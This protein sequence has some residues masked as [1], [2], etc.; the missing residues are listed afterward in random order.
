MTRSTV[1]SSPL[2]AGGYSSDFKREYWDVVP[3]PHTVCQDLVQRH[4]YAKGGS[5]TA[6]YCHGLVRRDNPERVVGIAWWL[7]PT[8]VAAESVS[9][10]WTR[11]LSLTRTVI[12]PGVPKNAATF[13]LSKSVKLIKIDGRL[14]TLVT[15]ADERAGHTGGVYRAANWTYVGRTGPYVKWVAEDG[16]QVAAK[17]TKARTKAEMEALGPVRLGSFHKHKYVLRLPARKYAP[18]AGGG[19]SRVP[20]PPSAVPGRT[21]EG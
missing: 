17:A 15:Y 18:T 19:T 14:H 11:V 20:G 21:T 8:R 3:V 6:V 2:S 9:D 16:R 7:P 1:G 10:D 12:E 13:L 4:H 5:N